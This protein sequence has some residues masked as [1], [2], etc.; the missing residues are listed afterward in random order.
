M[1]H[2]YKIKSWINDL[3]ETVYHLYKKRWFGLY[4]SAGYGS[5]NLTYAENMIK[6]DVE[7]M[8]K[9]KTETTYY[10]VEVNGDAIKMEKT[11]IEL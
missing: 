10:N 7:N 1:K 2:K 11:L 4:T 8:N 5:G 6:L 3:G 9:P